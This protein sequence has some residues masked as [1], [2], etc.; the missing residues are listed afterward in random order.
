MQEILDNNLVAAREFGEDQDPDFDEEV[1]MAD[2]ELK[3]FLWLDSERSSLF[4]AR[5]V[6]LCEGASEKVY[7][8]YL[9]DNEWGF[10]RESRVYV[11]DCLGKYNIHRFIHLLT[12]LGI[13]HSVVFDGDND[14]EHHSTWNGIIADSSTQLTHTIHQFTEDLEAFLGI[15]KPQGRNDLKPIN[16]IKHYVD[17]LIGENKKD[18]LECIVKRLIGV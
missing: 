9:A 10:L 1:R 3:Y 14:R 15:P 2:E 7:F 18:D 13:P 8:D 17:G 4:F 11:L 16:I 12:E 6:L 5:H